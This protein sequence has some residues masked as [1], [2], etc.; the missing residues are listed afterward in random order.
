MIISVIAE[1]ELATVI[2]AAKPGRSSELLAA[3]YRCGVLPKRREG[4]PDYCQLKSERL[5]LRSG[6]ASDRRFHPAH[7]IAR[8]DRAGPARR[9]LAAAE[10]DQRRNAADGTGRAGLRAR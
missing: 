8:C 5:A 9:F 1:L 2:R 7:E 4:P 6:P 3:F 10:Q